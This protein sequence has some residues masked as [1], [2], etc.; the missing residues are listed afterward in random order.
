M[1]AAPRVA[2]DAA[3][4][5]LGAAE[6]PELGRGGL[7]QDDPAF[8]AEATEAVYPFYL[9]HQT[10]A[11]IVVY[12]LLTADVPSVAGFILT[13][14]ATFLGTWLVYAGLVRPWG[15]VRPLF[16]MKPLVAR[17]GGFARSHGKPINVGRAAPRRTL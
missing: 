5:G 16:G 3:Q 2:R 17:Q 1:Q 12:G 11:V 9:I 4:Q 13:V 15:W 10:V 7:A 14:L 6:Q 8:L